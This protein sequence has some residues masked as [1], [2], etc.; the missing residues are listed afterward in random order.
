MK[1]FLISLC[2]LL[3]VLPGTPSLAEAGSD[4]PVDLPQLGAYGLYDC[5]TGACLTGKDVEGLHPVAGVSRLPALV[6]LAQAFDDGSIREDATL[7]VSP[8]AAGIPGPTAFLSENETIQAEPLLKAGV[9]ISAGDAITALY[10][11]AYGSENVFLE[12][13]AVT[14]KEAGVDMAMTDALGTGMAFSCNSLFQIGRAAANSSAYTKYSCLYLDQ[15]R[16]GDGRE[17]ELVSANRMVRFFAGCD[18]LLTGS[19]QTDGYSGVFHAV[20]NDMELICVI[21]GAKNSQDRSS[22]AEALFQ[23]GFSNFTVKHLAKEGNVFVP[24][25]PVRSGDRK[26]V[27]LVAKE[28]ISV[29]REKNAGKLVEER[30][31][32]EYLEAPL[33]EDTPVGEIRYVD[34]NG[35]IHATIPLYPDSPVARFGLLDILLKI[36]SDFSH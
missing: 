13:I 16:H 9:M 35:S 31:V 29:L 11:H 28:P 4:S 21:I 23:Y 26:T 1:R 25:L 17:T 12:N 24:A 6:T 10:E 2:I 22:A 32:P 19:S 8:R 18:G 15:I 14:L 5:A 7:Q 36:L 30:E 34:E 33:S 20:R 27:N 3:L